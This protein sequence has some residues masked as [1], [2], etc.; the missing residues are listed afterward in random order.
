MNVDAYTSLM[1]HS[2]ARKMMKVL[3]TLPDYEKR[4]KSII[5]SCK[6]LQFKSMK[7][8]LNAFKD[9]VGDEHYSMIATGDSLPAMLE[10]W[11]SD[12]TEFNSTHIVSSFRKLFPDDSEAANMDNEEILIAFVALASQI[13]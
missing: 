7:D 3:E 6:L 8:K 5:D 10:Q 2:N 11:I 9:D 13:S 1:A 4:V 12:R